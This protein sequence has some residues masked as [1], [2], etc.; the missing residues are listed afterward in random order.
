M[1]KIS[2]TARRSLRATYRAVDEIVPRYNSTRSKRQSLEGWASLVRNYNTW[3]CDICHYVVRDQSFEASQLPNDKCHFHFYFACVSFWRLGVR[4]QET[5]GIVEWSSKDTVTLSVIRRHED[6]WMHSR[7][8]VFNKYIVP[9]LFLWYELPCTTTSVAART[10]M[11]STEG[12]CW[13]GG[14]LAGLTCDP[15][16]LKRPNLWIY[17]QY[18]YSRL[19]VVALNISVRAKG[20]SVFSPLRLI[21]NRACQVTYAQKAGYSLRTLVWS[22]WMPLHDANPLSLCRTSKV[23]P[24]ISLTWGLCTRCWQSHGCPVLADWQKPPLLLPHPLR[25]NYLGLLSWSRCDHSRTSSCIPSVSYR[26]WAS[27]LPPALEWQPL[28]AA[29]TFSR[30]WPAARLSWL[31]A[32]GKVSSVWQRPER[33]SLSLPERGIRWTANRS[34]WIGCSWN[35]ARYITQQRCSEANTR[36]TRWSCTLAP[37]VEAI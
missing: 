8:W 12:P 13:G 16:L 31:F 34:N 2:D 28:T 37:Y 25:D 6:I 22:L 23:S 20:R 30:S 19:T 36:D 3:R 14:K 11:W 35:K 7:H 24:F 15:S 9:F 32:P 10:A 5:I 1:Y 18:D 29:T 4:R 21:P 26:A 17:K 33:D 27:R